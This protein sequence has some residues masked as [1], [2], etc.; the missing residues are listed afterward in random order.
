MIE[1]GDA[2]QKIIDE[3]GLVQVSDSSAIEGIIDTVLAGN[4]QSIDDYKNGK[5]K[6]IGFLVGQ[7]MKES[8][9]KA[10]PQVVNELLLK[11]LNQ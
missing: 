10:N 3:K 11:K 4:Q 6:A 9:G 8:K 5:E 1:S 7:I 2:P